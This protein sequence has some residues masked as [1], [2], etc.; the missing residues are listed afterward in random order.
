[1]AKYFSGMSQTNFLDGLVSQTGLNGHELYDYL[2]ECIEKNPKAKEEISLSDIK[3]ESLR[4]GRVFCG[5]Y[6][7][8]KEYAARE[9]VPE[10]SVRLIGASAPS[11]AACVVA[12]TLGLKWFMWE[13]PNDLTPCNVGAYNHKTK[14][15]DIMLECSKQEWKKNFDRLDEIFQTY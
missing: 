11:F 14:K 12:G 15:W 9:G 7:E 8:L 5:S 6:Q 10:D 2:L 13:R 3:T 1:M 4:P